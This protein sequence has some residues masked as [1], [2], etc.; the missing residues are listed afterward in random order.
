MSKRIVTLWIA[1]ICAALALVA[2]ATILVRSP[3]KSSTAQA[4]TSTTLQPGLSG[5]SV[6][7]I[8]TVLVKPDVVKLTVGVEERATTVTEAQKQAAT[9]LEAITTAVKDLGVKPEDIATLSYNIR[10]NYVYNNQQSPRLDGYIVNSQLSLTIRDIP[11]AGAI[12]D[13][14]GNAGANL[15]GGIS[16]TLDNNTEAV[17]QARQAA[18]VDAKSR[19][20]QLAQA[21]GFGLGGVVNVTEFGGNAPLAVVQTGRTDAV[22]AAPVA[23]STVIEGGQFRVVVNVQVIYAIK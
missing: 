10:P 20:E 2:V 23:A 5:V 21:G 8:G 14:A 15:A 6:Q 18:M 4:Q 17:K 11:K 16:F 7:G 22:A 3:E 19:A 13:A 1:G 12:I 9:K